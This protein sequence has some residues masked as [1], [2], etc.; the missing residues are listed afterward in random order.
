[1][2]HSLATHRLQ[3]AVHA[4]VKVLLLTLLLGMLVAQCDDTVVQIVHQ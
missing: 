3:T 1:M 2:H 4:C